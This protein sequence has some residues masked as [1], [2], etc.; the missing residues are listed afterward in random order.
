MR[1]V[2]GIIHLMDMSLSKPWEMVKDREAQHAAV[3]GLTKSRT[4]LSDWTTKITF[5]FIIEVTPKIYILDMVLNHEKLGQL[6]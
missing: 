5:K 3:H 2:D 4:W 6:F 1:W